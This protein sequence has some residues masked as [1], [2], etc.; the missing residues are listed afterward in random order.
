MIG[1]R[2]RVLREEKELRQSDLAKKLGVSQQTISQYEK[3]TREPDPAMTNKIA[4]FFGVSIDYLYGNSSE[5]SPADKIKSALSEDPELLKFWD[6]LKEREDLQLMFK[7]T[8]DLSP[9]SI[10]QIME[11]I[12]IF[13]KEQEEKYNGG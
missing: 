9:K 12:K 2:L 3:D 4:S 8:R 5:R 10:K 11:I 1:N 13:E 7:Q 6:E